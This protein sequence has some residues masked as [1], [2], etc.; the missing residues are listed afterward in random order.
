[1]IDAVKTNNVPLYHKCS[2]DMAEMFY[3]YGGKNYSRFL[4][5]FDGFLTNIEFTHPG[6]TKLLESGAIAVARSLV[7]GN[8]SMVDKTMEETLMFFGK[9]KQG[10]NVHSA[11]MQL[12]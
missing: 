10:K 2:R 12:T 6:A 3:V 4:T 7:T 1:M 9:S 5:W 8:L 11:I